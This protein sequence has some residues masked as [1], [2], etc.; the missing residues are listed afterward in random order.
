VAVVSR[1]ELRAWR[2]FLDA[3]ASV[4]RR[5]EDELVASEGMTLAELDALI[6]L[7]FASGG[8]LRMTELSERVR[9]SRSGLTRLVDR[10]VSEGLIERGSCASDRRG[11]FAI[12]TS[13]GRARLRRARPIHLK[14]V[15]EHFGRRLSVAQ[16]SAIA[17]ALEPLGQDMRTGPLARDGG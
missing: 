6:Q 1:A 8:R 3:Q 12:I 9:L 10:L 11:S 7:R 14:G 16:L 5:L 2:A 17:D 13:A 15:H 4:L